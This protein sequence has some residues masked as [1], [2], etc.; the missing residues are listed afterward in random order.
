MSCQPATPHDDKKE[1]KGIKYHVTFVAYRGRAAQSTRS[2]IL[3]PLILY[4][5]LLVSNTAISTKFTTEGLCRPPACYLVAYSVDGGRS[6]C[7]ILPIVPLNSAILPMVCIYCVL[8]LL[9]NGRE[10]GLIVSGRII[11]LSFQSKNI[12]Q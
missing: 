5:K 8:K 12:S 3:Y 6:S 7:N 9:L 4:T 2:F 1:R 10:T 11:A